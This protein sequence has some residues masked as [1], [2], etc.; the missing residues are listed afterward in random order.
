MS[1]ARPNPRCFALAA[2]AAFAFGLMAAGLGCETQ[3]VEDRPERVVQEFV[4]RMRRVHGEEGASRSAHDL[5]WLEAKNNLAERA[6]RASAVS[7]RKVA[8]EDMLAPS[9]FTLRFEPRRYVAREQGDVA[10]VTAIG[11]D[12][13]QRAEIK[14]VREAG[15]W[16]VALALPVPPP[17]T[18]RAESEP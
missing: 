6:K 8:P 7:D 2:G 5:L 17:I 11:E 9:H 18:R 15:L 12:A 13:N 16:R 1:R 14:C 3:S 4:E 10:I